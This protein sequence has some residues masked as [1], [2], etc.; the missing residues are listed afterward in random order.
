MFW[1]SAHLFLWH[2]HLFPPAGQLELPS[3]FNEFF[4]DNFFSSLLQL[5][6]FISNLTLLFSALQEFFNWDAVLVL[7]NSCTYPPFLLR[8]LAMLCPTSEKQLDN[9]H[10]YFVLEYWC[11]VHHQFVWNAPLPIPIR[12]CWVWNTLLAILLVFLVALWWWLF[13]WAQTP[14]LTVLCVQFLCSEVICFSNPTL[15]ILM[16]RF[17]AII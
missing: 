12:S 15:W 10:L 8:K 3:R 16:W 5:A 1:W 11:L 13:P 2:R 7:K 4:F 9:F 14:F 17:I 6:K